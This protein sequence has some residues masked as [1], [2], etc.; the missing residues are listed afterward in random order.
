M[1]NIEKTVEI[2]ETETLDPISAQQAAKETYCKMEAQLVEAFAPS[3]VDQEVTCSS[4]GDGK[5]T[6]LTG[7][8]LDSAILEIT[9]GETVKRF[10]LQHVMTN[11]FIQFVNAASV[12]DLWATAFESHTALVTAYQESDRTFRQLQADA[13]KKAKADKKAEENYQKLKEKS[14]KDFE[15]LT[16]RT[17]THSDDDAFYYSLGWLAKHIGTLSAALPDYLSEAFTKYFGAETPCRIVDSKH[18]GPAGWQAQWSWSFRASLKKAEN[19]PSNL[20]QYLNPTGNAV[21]NLTFLWSLVDNY[22]FKFGKKQD[23]EEIAKTIPAKYI[24]AFNEGLA[25]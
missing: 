9:F 5:V 3:L 19:I 23:V 24:D 10:S 2:N 7:K 13:D 18:R 12:A 15:E 1:D 20:T 14:I 16:T 11:K 4:Y 8:T 25:S 22:G 21:T 17:F 6:A